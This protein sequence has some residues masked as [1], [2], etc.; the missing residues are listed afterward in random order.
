MPHTKRKARI[1][2]ILTSSPDVLFRQSRIDEAFRGMQSAS[3][4]GAVGVDGG[5]RT[6]HALAEEISLIPGEPTTP[7]FA[8]K[9]LLEE[10]TEHLLEGT[11]SQSLETTFDPQRRGM[12]PVLSSEIHEILG[13]RRGEAE[14]R[15]EELGKEGLSDKG[16]DEKDCTI[17]AEDKKK[18][19]NSKNKSSW[20]PRSVCSEN[21]QLGH[22][23]VSIEGQPACCFQCVPCS[24]GEITN[25][26]NPT[27]CRKCPEDQWPNENQDQCLP[28]QPQF[29]SY[30]ETMGVALAAAAITFSL[31]TLSILAIFRKYSETPVVKANNRNLSYLLLMALTLCFLSALVF[32][33]HPVRVT[34]LLRQ[35]IFGTTFSITVSCMLAKTVTVIIA[36]KSTKPN[37]LG[38]K[39]GSK[40]TSFIVLFCPLVQVLICIIWLASS[41][42]FPE[43]NMKSKSDKIMIECNE[44][45]PLFFYCMLGYLGVLATV[46]FI[47]AFLARK[48]PDSFNEG[49][50]IT[51]SMF[52]FLSVW[53]CFIPA[54]LSAEGKYIVAVEIFSILASS[55][56][57]LSCLFFPKC[58]I[59]IFRPDMNTKQYVRGKQA[60]T[61]N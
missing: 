59:I 46:S 44:G 4:S 45:S 5:E 57:L 47:V 3:E 11:S 16:G 52:V 37:M 60:S 19:K 42:P 41:P 53:L 13:S 30:D 43:S 12:E 25:E 50:F 29:L 49:K 18:R 31:L 17:Y 7:S 24:S 23:K 28:R 32:I 48:L 8:Y 54:Y 58:Y 39:L 61:A 14:M 38:K 6:P 2:E 26:N 56:G 22:R 35:T 34:C 40:V 36:F 33:G 20:I 15:R 27:L 21:C 51:F 10:G 1:R 9:P 55:A